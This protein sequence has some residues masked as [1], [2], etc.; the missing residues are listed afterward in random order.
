MA[1][2]YRIVIYS[3]SFDDA[4]DVSVIKEDEKSWEYGIGRNEEEAVI[5]KALEVKREAFKSRLVLFDKVERRHICNKSS[6][7]HIGH[8]DNDHFGNDL[9]TKF[10]MSVV[11]GF[12]LRCSDYS[13]EKW[14]EKRNDD[15]VYKWKDDVAILNCFLFL[16]EFLGQSDN[17]KI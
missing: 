12:L 17:Q 2:S 4:S 11:V 3:V 14:T 13:A 8:K 6:E 7:E 16:Y 10:W 1:Y 5:K 9:V 15:W